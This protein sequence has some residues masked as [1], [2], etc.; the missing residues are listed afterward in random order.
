MAEQEKSAPQTPPSAPKDPSDEAK[1]S[2]EYKDWA[3][4]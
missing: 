2:F 4:L 3:A 1:K